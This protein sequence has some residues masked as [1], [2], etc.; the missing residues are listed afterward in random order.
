MTQEHRI[1]LLEMKLAFQDETIEKLNQELIELNEIV[2]FQ[3]EQLNYLTSKIQALGGS[4]LAS[5]DEE[6]PPPHY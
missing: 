6:T 5:E 2:A 1:D 4:N 3:K